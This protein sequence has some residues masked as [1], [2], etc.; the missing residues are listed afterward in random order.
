MSGPGSLQRQTA[1]EGARKTARAVQ[2]R[3]LAGGSVR[4]RAGRPRTRTRRQ[5]CPAHVLPGRRPLRLGRQRSRLAALHSGRLP[6][7]GR[8]HPGRTAAAGAQATRL[9]AGRP[10]RV[11]Q[12]SSRLTFRLRVPEGVAFGGL[13]L[14]PRPLS[15]PRAE[16]R[17]RGDERHTTQGAMAFGARGTRSRSWWARHPADS[18]ESP[19]TLFEKQ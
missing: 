6:V 12:G 9:Q 13:V 10:G 15:R 16:L 18:A 2:G 11:A 1:R 3:A 7:S 5:A 14:P 19:C 4:A 8:L 17:R